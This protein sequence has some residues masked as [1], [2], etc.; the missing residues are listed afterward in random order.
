MF[1]GIPDANLQIFFQALAENQYLRVLAEP[2]LV[3][4]SGEEANFL[5]GGEFPIPVVQG[6]TQNTSITIEYRE[7]GVR[8]H[9]HPIVLGD[10][11]IRLM[12]E[13]E[14]SNLTDVGAVEIQGFRVPA[15]NTR[16]AQTTLELKSGQTFAVAGLLNRTNDARRSSIP[17]LGDIPVL[18]VLFRSVRYQSGETELAVLVT[19]SIVQPVSA[20][21]PVPGPGADYTMPGDWEFYVR[22][23][24]EGATPWKPLPPATA[25]TDLGLEKLHGP[26]AWADYERG[27]AKSQATLRPS[28]APRADTGSDAPAAGSTKP[29]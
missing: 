13:Q 21:T 3:A 20:K 16:R 1:T 23:E 9:F 11:T 18:G 14:L 26:G 7:F 5:A 15:L 6:T 17:L 22:G 24:I 27:M 2:N 28:P 10:G 4:M 12:V 19:P 8:L 29:N 25:I